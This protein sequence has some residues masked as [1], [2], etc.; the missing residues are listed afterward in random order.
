MASNRGRGGAEQDAQLREE[1]RRLG[2]PAPGRD[3][4]LDRDRL[5]ARVEAEESI[6][7]AVRPSPDARSRRHGAGWWIVSAVVAAALV[8]V[9]YTAHLFGPATVQPGGHGTHAGQR[10]GGSPAPVEAPQKY[11]AVDFLNARDGWVAGQD[12]QYS[13]GVVLRTTDGGTAWARTALPGD[14]ILTLQFEDQQ[15]GWLIAETAC[16]GSGCTQLSVLGTADG[17]KTWQQEWQTA[18]DTHSQAMNVLLRS[19]VDA[20][21]PDVFALALGHLVATTD[22]GRTWRDLTLPGDATPVDAAFVDASHGWVAAQSCSGGG[23]T[24]SRCS[25]AVYVTGDG[26]K[27]WNRSVAPHLTHGYLTGSA[28][29]SFADP[30]H[31]WFFFKNASLQG[32]LFRTADGGRSW[33]Q[34]NDN[35]ASGR[36]VSG[37]PVFVNAQYGWIPV[38]EGAAPFPGAIWRTIDGGRT[39]TDVSKG[40]NWSIRA[41][42]AVVRGAGA[43][44]QLWAISD[45]SNGGNFLT[46]SEDGGM[47]WQQVMPVLGPL[48]GI[49]FADDRHGMGIG[50]AANPNAVLVTADGGATW[51]QTASLALRP[52]SIA[53]ASAT[54][55]LIVAYNPSDYRQPNVLRSTDDGRTWQQIASL[56]PRLPPSVPY[57]AILGRNPAVDLIETVDFPAK[58]AF[59]V[60]RDGGKTWTP[61]GSLKLPADAMPGPQ[62]A[63]A[64]PNVGYVTEQVQ[65]PAAFRLLLYKTTDGGQRWMQLKDLGMHVFALALSFPDPLH[66]RLLVDKLDAQGHPSQLALMT[67]ADGGRSWAAI[68]FNGPSGALKAIVNTRSAMTFA[69]AAH[70]WITTSHGMLLRTT[71]GGKTWTRP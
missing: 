52:V 70:G 9:G 69:D 47:K 21:G 43:P 22:G 28:A 39:W 11:D 42:D 12:A 62:V 33:Q 16:H 61:R 6:R 66:G 30:Q 25:A 32:D 5:W 26:G 2:L 4:K 51:K 36:T 59:S 19:R 56:S 65:R 24:S 49:T 34:V 68:P 3:L 64:N 60:S 13:Q 55:A 14:V 29:V 31:G 38:D 48:Y 67:T 57:L 37:H 54:D 17:G 46:R 45:Q 20:F 15:R 40:K 18:V 63:F 27:T 44:L 8:F 53:E 23:A 1:F 58:T 35:L 10:H 71:D 41:V 50:T 7:G